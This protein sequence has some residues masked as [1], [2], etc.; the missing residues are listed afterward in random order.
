MLS[1]TVSTEGL[2]ISC[3]IDAMECRE[4]ATA[5]IPGALLLTDYDNGYIHIKLEGLMVTLIEEIDPDYCRYL[6]YTDKS[7]RKCMYAEAR[8]AIYGTL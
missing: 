5:N 1:P 3:M 7:G 2:V 4:L 6:I 8:K